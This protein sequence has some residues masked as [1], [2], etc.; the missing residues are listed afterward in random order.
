MRL[1]IQCIM[2]NGHIG[3]PVD[4]QTHTHITE[5]NYLPA[6]SLAGGKKM[7]KEPSDNWMHDLLALHPF[8]VVL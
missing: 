6:T 3:T 4:R 1:R 5:N 7:P 8:Y 2:G